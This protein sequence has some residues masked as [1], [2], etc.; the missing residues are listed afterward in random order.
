MCVQG[1][2]IHPSLALQPYTSEWSHALHHF[3]K[4][5]RAN[6]IPADEI[7]PIVILSPDPP[8]ASAWI[9]LA[10]FP[11]LYYVKGVCVCAQLTLSLVTIVSLGP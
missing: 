9:V 10:Y 6:I 4:R 2:S 8:P 1:P 7:K 5:M 3:V 11:E